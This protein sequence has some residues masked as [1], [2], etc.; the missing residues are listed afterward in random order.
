MNKKGTLYSWTPIFI[1]FY[2]LLIAVLVGFIVAFNN[3]QERCEVIC[4][5]NNEAT[6][7]LNMCVDLVNELADADINSNFTRLNCKEICGR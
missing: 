6:T 4:D 5:I 7:S 1:F 3:V 2:V